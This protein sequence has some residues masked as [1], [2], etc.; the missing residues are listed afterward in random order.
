MTSKKLWAGNFKLAFVL[1][2][3]LIMLYPAFSKAAT[4]DATLSLTPSTRTVSTGTDVTLT[5]RVNPGSNTAPGVNAVQIDLTYDSSILQLEAGSIAP[6]SPFTIAVGPTEPAGNKVSV[7]LM[8]GGSQVTTTHDVAQFT[9]R[10]LTSGTATVS[11]DSTSDAA[12]NGTLV[13][14][15][16]N[17]A[18]V[19][20]TDNPLYPV[21][22][23]VTGL[24][25]TVTLQNES[26]DDLSLSSNG[27]FS[28][29]T[30]LNSGDPYSVTVS[31]QPSG[32]TCSVTGGSGTV[33]SPGVSNISLSCSGS[34]SSSSSSSSSHSSSHHHKKAKHVIKHLHISPISIPVFMTKHK[35]DKIWWNAICEKGLDHYSYV[36]KGVIVD[37]KNPYFL[38]PNTVISGSTYDLKIKVFDLKG[39][40]RYKKVRLRIL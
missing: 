34:G 33:S 9:F 3:L 36:L 31:S 5:A 20:V 17:G 27:A 21:G 30:D 2:G 24:N 37:T 28:F 15:T 29:P 11:L 25:G 16:R 4:T 40:M 13:V 12:V 18:T 14:S 38:I 39:N 19:N 22:G 35:G 7:A 26:G 23:T 10:T 8:D 32:Q 6:A 1:A